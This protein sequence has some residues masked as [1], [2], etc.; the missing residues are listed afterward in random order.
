LQLACPYI[1]VPSPTEE[2]YGSEVHIIPVDFSDGFEIYAQ[3]AE[4]LQ[5]LDI[6]V[7]GEEL[8]SPGIHGAVCL[9]YLSAQ[10]AQKD[11][12][13]CFHIS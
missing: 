3:I 5:D 11:V 9:I 4:K 13:V 12:I 10:S 7:L 1:H 2:K 6:G 8:V